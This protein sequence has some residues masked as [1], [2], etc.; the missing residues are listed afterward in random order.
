MHELAVPL[1]QK[2]NA[3]QCE[4][5]QGSVTFDNA[6]GDAG[7]RGNFV[8]YYYRFKIPLCFDNSYQ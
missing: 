5:W 7:C 6:L 3:K 2:G 1:I 8:E 4:I